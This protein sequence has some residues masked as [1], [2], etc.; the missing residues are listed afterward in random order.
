MSDHMDPQEQIIQLGEQIGVIEAKMDEI[1]RRVM[2]L[3]NRPDP[4]PHHDP[5]HDHDRGE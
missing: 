4:D 5:H 1:D 2:A 3:E